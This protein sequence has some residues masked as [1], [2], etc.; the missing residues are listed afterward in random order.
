MTTLCLFAIPW[1][2]GYGFTVGAIWD[3]LMIATWLFLWYLMT[4]SKGAHTG[5]HK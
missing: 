1:L 5:A 4:S 3:G 2:A